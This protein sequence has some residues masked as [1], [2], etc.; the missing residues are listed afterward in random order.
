MAK[1]GTLCRSLSSWRQYFC[2]LFGRNP[3][4]LAHPT[5]IFSH[6]KVPNGKLLGILNEK[7][8]FFRSKPPRLYDGAVF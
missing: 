4:K 5:H 3:Q 8:G 1:T 7:Y 6:F 2:D